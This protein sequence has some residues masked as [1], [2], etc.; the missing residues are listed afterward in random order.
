MTNGVSRV[1]TVYNRASIQCVSQKGAGYPNP[2]PNG[3][4]YSPTQF[5]INPYGGNVYIGS[6]SSSTVVKGTIDVKGFTH[7]GS[8]NAA[9]TIY[10]SNMSLFNYIDWDSAAGKNANLTIKIEDDKPHF[11][12]C[13][14]STGNPNLIFDGSGW[15]KTHDIATNNCLVIISILNGLGGYYIT[16]I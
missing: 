14:K 12:F 4:T 3:Q 16:G 15:S 5:T 9:K 1:Y 11:I 13:K 8:F 7:L 2:D 6:T 10:T